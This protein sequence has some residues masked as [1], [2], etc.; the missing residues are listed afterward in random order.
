LQLLAIGSIQTSLNCMQRSPTTNVFKHHLAI[1]SIFV[2]PIDYSGYP[3]HISAFGLFVRDIENSC[4][5]AGDFLKALQDAIEMMSSA[6]TTVADHY[7]SG[8]CRTGG[9]ITTVIGG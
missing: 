6:S 9:A 2:S 4:Y 3:A 5:C 7:D 1:P 8:S